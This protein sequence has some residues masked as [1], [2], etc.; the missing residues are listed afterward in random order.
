M[1]RL[2]LALCAPIALIAFPVL[3]AAQPVHADSP[4]VT[5]VVAQEL[6]VGTT[7]LQPGD[8][9]FQCRTFDGKTFLVVTSAADGREITRVPCVREML[10][11]KVTDSEYRTL[12]R[13]DG[14]RTLTLVRIKG[15]AVAHRI[16][17]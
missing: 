5:I 13:P 15:E 16:V 4:K 8:Y 2:M 1:K 6:V 10:D 3:A 9:K 14:K 7:I 17:D 11:G 12:L